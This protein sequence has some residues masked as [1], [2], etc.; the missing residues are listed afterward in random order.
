MK[1]LANPNQQR[2]MEVGGMMTGG[3][4]QRLASRRLQ[5]VPSRRV[6]RASLPKDHLGMHLLL[7]SIG[8]LMH[9][10][11]EKEGKDR[12]LLLGVAVEA[13]V[14]GRHRLGG[15]VLIRLKQFSLS[16][17][18]E[19]N[20][21]GTAGVDGMDGGEV[22]GVVITSSGVRLLLLRLHC[23]LLLLVSSDV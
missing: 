11:A 20:Q 13:K 4:Q 14:K 7:L 8:F 16:Q 6:L 18:Q 21:D 12:H 19:Q 23:F 1:S 5:R 17:I 15:V 10:V 22:D 3:L 2:S 9:G